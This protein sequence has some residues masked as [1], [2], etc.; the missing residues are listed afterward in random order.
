M[1][2]CSSAD[3]LEWEVLGYRRKILVVMQQLAA[4]FQRRDSNDAIVG[5]ADGNAL[6]A[7]FAVDIR[8]PDKYRL[9]HRQ[10]DQGAE[11]A[12]HTPVGGDIGNPLEDLGQDDTAQ[13]QV[14][15]VEDA[16]LQYLDMGQVGACEEVDPDASV[17]QDH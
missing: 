10:Y 4:V 17:N 12:P 7:Q 3:D 15:I 8:C 5:L 1:Y 16:L 6:L 11:I 9:W 13:G 2:L 14:L